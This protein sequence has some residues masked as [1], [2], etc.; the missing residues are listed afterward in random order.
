MTN[1]L[2]RTELLLDEEKMQRLKDANVLVVGLGGVGAYASEMICRA[3]VGSMTIVDGDDVHTTNRNRQLPALKSTEGKP[4]ARVMAGRL[5]D[6][7][8]DINLTVIQEY[9]KDE[10]ME[11][12][13]DMGFDYV[14]DAIDTLSPKIFLIYH[15]MQRKIPL[16]SSMGAGGKFDPSRVLIADI[17][18]TTDCTLARILRKRLHRLGIRE[19]FTAVFSDE[20]IDKKKIIAT[21][22]EQNKASVVGT[23]SYMPATFGIACA[24]VVIRDLAGIKR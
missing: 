1:W 8:P 22:G 19:G 6:I 3:G 7:N 2:T 14:V 11:E 21:N 24:S 20:A 16:V 5:L 15:T 18:E 17:S 10:R 9:I 4:K 13:I 23:I 12:I